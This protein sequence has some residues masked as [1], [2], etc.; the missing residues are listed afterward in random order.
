VATRGRPTT[1][2]AER[3]E[4]IA[5]QL[6]VAVTRLLADGGSY[7]D[8]PINDIVAEAG[9]AKSTAY[10]YFDGKNDLLQTMFHSVVAEVT[11]GHG[12]LDLSGPSSY[13][14]FRDRVQSGVAI[15]RPYLPVLTAGFD[16]AYFD[17][18]VREHV[19]GLGDAWAAELAAQITTG[20]RN[21]WIDPELLPSETAQW[22]TWMVL[23]GLHKLA[24]GADDARVV[25]LGDSL[26]R[27]VWSILYPR[28]RP[29]PGAAAAS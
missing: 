9:L 23:R 21:G 18:D 26:T 14:G 12:R 4:A 20:Q 19:L 6:L 25:E 10:R 16:A 29:Q 24:V 8:L 13:Q 22:I 1:T 28:T 15:Y 11:E 17:A 7:A 27:V 3:R 5:S 2:H